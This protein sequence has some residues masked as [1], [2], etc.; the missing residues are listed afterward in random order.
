MHCPGPEGHGVARHARCLSTLLLER[1]VRV[2]ESG[3]DLVH[4][5]F[6]D[7]LYDGAAATAA[8]AFEGWAAG[9][10]GPVVVTVHDLPGDDPDPGRDARRGA[11]YR[12]VLDSGARVVVS[13]GHEAEKV[14]A[15]T[16]EKPDVIPLPLPHRAAHAGQRRR[17]AL[18]VAGFVYPGKGHEEVIRAAARHPW[19]PEVV[20]LGAASAGHAG[21]AAGLAAVAEELGVRFTVTGTLDDPGMAAGLSAVAVPVAPARR[22]SASGSVMS[23]LSVGRRPLVAAGA[24]SR[25]LAAMAPSAVHLYETDQDLDDLVDRALRDEAVT[26]AAGPA[27]WFDVGGMHRD[28]YAS[29]LEASC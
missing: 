21:L 25:E 1:G 6:S 18:G 4:V 26:R 9:V 13:A 3:A 12:R 16:G 2:V 24:Y 7:S 22:V 20:A 8:S 29:V 10:A 19:R 28:L 23:W 17:T 15:L 14:L 5:Q 27:R 11:A